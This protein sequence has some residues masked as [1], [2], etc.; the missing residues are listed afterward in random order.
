[1]IRRIADVRDRW[2]RAF[3]LAAV[4]LA[5]GCCYLW[6]ARTAYGRFYW[7]HDLGGYYDYLS[8]GFARGHL[9]LSIEPSPELLALP[10]PWDPAVDPDF[11]F[12][13]QDMVL[14]NRRYYLYH[15][16]GPA[17]MLFTPWRLIS[18]HD[19]PEPFAAFLF[20][21]GG[22]LFSC[23]A[24]LRILRMADA[25][26]S[27][28]LLAIMLLALGLCQCAPYLLNR[29]FV[30]E[31]ALSAGYFSIAAA[32]YFLARAIQSRFGAHWLAASGLMFGVAISCRPHL[33]LAGVLAAAG[34]AASRVRWRALLVF[35]APFCLAGAAVAAYNYARFG[36]P[37][38]F[39]LRYLLA[40]QDQQ[41]IE[42][43]LPYV[44]PGLYFQVFCAPGLTAV[45]PWVRQVFRNPFNSTSRGFPPG[46]FIEQM[47]G[48]LYLAP[49]LAGTL[50][51]PSAMRRQS[52]GIRMLLWVLPASAAAILLFLAAT[53]FASQRY[54][55]DFLPLAVLAGVAAIGIH[56]ARCTGWRRAVLSVVFALSVAFGAVVGLALG[57]AGPYDDILKNA[58]ATYLRVAR[59]FSPIE[60]FRP[61]MNPRV[62]VDL[63]AR[64]VPHDDGFRE[65]LVT[66]G[67]RTYRYFLY[68]EHAAGK[69]R[70][71]SRADGSSMTH[72]ME[73]PTGRTPAIRVTYSP[74]SGNITTAI[75]G[76]DVL[77]HRIQTL[78]TAPAQVTVGENQI[79]DD[80][81]V[82]RFTGQIR[83]I[84]LRF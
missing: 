19:V 70:I 65:P 67:Q 57:I 55:L 45:F 43:S 11:K 60:R 74:E 75:D 59:W 8:R 23:G 81:T 27:P 20:C 71:V 47:T 51:I 69:L 13:M 58:P 66:M 64:L 2:V 83:L 28:P 18:G 5:V 72:E 41:R 26:P 82:E 35:L 50:L 17:V 77:V 49:F 1:M 56:I 29:V 63:S 30:Y 3:V 7:R 9:Y 76:E 46:Y 38:E 68:A 84:S 25:M 36:N 33:G 78:V 61:V 15:G 34:I 10:N 80:V 37:L 22:F 62:T 79:D 54:Q 6:I 52:G 16:A 44:L 14:F 32:V 21:F 24:L 40:G 48:A 39:G 4:A 12:K 42:L 31:I 73:M 53:G